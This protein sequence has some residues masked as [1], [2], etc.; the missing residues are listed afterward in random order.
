MGT[1]LWPLIPASRMNPM[2]LALRYLE[3]FYS[4]HGLDRLAELFLPALQFEG[5]LFTFTSAEAYIAALQQDP[6]R[7]M[8]YQILHTFAVGNKV[9]IIYTLTK[10]PTGSPTL[11]AALQTPLAQIFETDGTHITRILL[12]FDTKGF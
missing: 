8:T 2:D 3:I 11:N 9:C 12:I 1:P 4:G 7:A 10:H 6:P 5:P